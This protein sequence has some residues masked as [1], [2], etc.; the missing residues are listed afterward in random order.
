M[1]PVFAIVNLADLGV[2]QYYFNLEKCL[3]AHFAILSSLVSPI[4]HIGFCISKCDQ[5]F[6]P[7]LRKVNRILLCTLH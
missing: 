3:F 2:N 5:H 6:S 1:L 4:F 7:I